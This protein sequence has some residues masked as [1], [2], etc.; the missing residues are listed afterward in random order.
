MDEYLEKLFADAYK[1]EL[2]QEENVVRSLPFIAAIAS[3]TLPVLR[4]FGDGL[5]PLDGAIYI[6]VVVEAAAE[7]SLASPQA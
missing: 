4:E 2:E 3:V 5:R 6:M 1:R 7:I